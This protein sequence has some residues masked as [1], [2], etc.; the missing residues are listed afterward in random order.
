MYKDCFEYKK[1]K[2][3]KKDKKKRY[4]FNYVSPLWNIICFNRS[5]KGKVRKI[6]SERD[7]FD[8]N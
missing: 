2:N 5:F 6:K 4:K 3:T 8:F 7:V 1:F